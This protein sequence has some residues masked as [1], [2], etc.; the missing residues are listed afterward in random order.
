MSVPIV[1]LLDDLSR[2]V[3]IDVLP[4]RPVSDRN[5]AK[6][7]SWLSAWSGSRRAQVRKARK[8]KGFVV[9]VEVAGGRHAEI[10]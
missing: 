3:A 10:L 4:T 1:L 2:A 7:H 8:I 6:I 5:P 9:A